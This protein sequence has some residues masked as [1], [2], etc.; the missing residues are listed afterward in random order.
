MSNDLLHWFKS[1]DSSHSSTN[2]VDELLIQNNVL[3]LHWDRGA[4]RPNQIA[5]ISEVPEGCNVEKKIRLRGLGEVTVCG[6][7]YFETETD[8]YSEL[9]AFEKKNDY[10]E[11]R[12]ASL[13]KSHLQKCVRRKQDT[14]SVLTGFHLMRLNLLEFC[15]RFPII[16]IEDSCLH[17]C[18]SVVCW[19]MAMLPGIEID[20]RVVHYLLGCVQ[21]VSMSPF[22]DCA[23]DEQY[24][25]HKT[26]TIKD[27]EIR[28]LWNRCTDLPTPKATLL[29]SLLFRRSF[30]GMKSDGAMLLASCQYWIKQS[31]KLSQDRFFLKIRP[32]TI[33]RYLSI[34]EM[35]LSAVDFHCYPGMI[36]KLQTLYPEYTVENLREMIWDYRS[37]LNLRLPPPYI[38]T[39]RHSLNN[40]EKIRES[41]DRISR[42]Y[43]YHCQ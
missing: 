41:I 33:K 21:F 39:P 34:R 15:R 2:K 17:N 42:N 24:Y 14:L 25:R 36:T 1:S 18:F 6:H 32:I 26:N 27:K 40:W 3:Y 31:T 13:L 8:P 11:F 5:W 35:E 4:K 43:I 37:S 30:G 20:T 16:M 7:Y 19:F 9:H 28:Q 10:K 29:Q 22:T 12:N 38:L 23:R